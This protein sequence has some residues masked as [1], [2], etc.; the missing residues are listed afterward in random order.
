MK[1][2]FM[3]MSGSGNDF[4]LIDHREPFLKEDHLKDFIRKV[5]QR[6][7]SVGA[8]G[9]ILI[10]PSQKADFKW[11]FYNADGSEAEMCGNGGRCA[12]L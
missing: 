6:R 11:R 9:L 10:E 8:D 1:I 7:V 2:L 5:C 3:K 12:P 4:I